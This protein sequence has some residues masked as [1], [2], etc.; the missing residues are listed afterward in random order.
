MIENITRIENR[1]KFEERARSITRPGTDI[2]GLLE[3]L[4]SGGFF[5]APQTERAHRSYD[6]GLCEHALC[7]YEEMKRI[8]SSSYYQGVSDDSILITSLFAD[9]GKMDY[10]DKTIKNKKVYSDTGKKSDE[11]GKFDWVSEPG[12]TVRDPA[13]RFVFGTLGQNSERILSEFVPLSNEES[14]AIINLHADYENPGLNLATIYM[15]Y[16]IAVFLNVADKLAS[17]VDTREDIIPF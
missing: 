8:C 6:G 3:A 2:D 17:F 11:L 7:R 1:A 15:S 14:A 13:L 10:F 5:E 12:Y 4:E 9:L 16:P